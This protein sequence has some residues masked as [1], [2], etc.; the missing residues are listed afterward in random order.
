MACKTTPSSKEPNMKSRN[1]PNE[2]EKT[3]EEENTMKS[4]TKN[5]SQDDTTLAVKDYRDHEAWSASLEEHFGS[6]AALSFAFGSDF[7][8][9]EIEQDLIGLKTKPAGTHL[10]QVVSPLADI[11]PQQFLISYDYNFLWQMRCELIN[12]R[13]RAGNGASMEAR[14]VLEEL[15]IYLCNDETAGYI[16]SIDANVV[17][18][19]KDEKINND[20]IYDLFDDSDI[21]TFLYSD[22][23][24][25]GDHT[26]HFSH[27][28]EKEFNAQ[29]FLQQ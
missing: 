25:P 29:A 21:I 26:Y 13:K 20:W 14:S 17:F 2:S 18:D 24:L 19:R 27:W 28:G 9:E 7:L 11:L 15:I 1:K 12:M 6:W 16:E 5:N 3:I 4:T 8:L 23:W 22:I 10:G